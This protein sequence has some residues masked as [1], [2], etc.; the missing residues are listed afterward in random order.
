VQAGF[1]E[2][3]SPAAPQLERPDATEGGAPAV[4]EPHPPPGPPRPHVATP[5]LAHPAAPQAPG[6]GWWQRHQRQRQRQQAAAGSGE[7]PPPEAPVLNLDESF[8]IWCYKWV[9]PGSEG[10]QGPAALPLPQAPLPRNK[11]RAP[12]GGRRHQLAGRPD[13]AAPVA[14]HCCP[15]MRACRVWRAGQAGAPSRHPSPI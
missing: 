2:S 8:L 14:T 7:S 15:C 11:G 10:V 1:L 9:Q 12:K 13:H 6:L 4:G 3:S 5:A